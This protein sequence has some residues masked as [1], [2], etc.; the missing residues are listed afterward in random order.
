[1][2]KPKASLRLS[3]ETLDEIDKFGTKRGDR[4]R[5]IEGAIR[6]RLQRYKG[7]V[8]M[9]LPPMTEE[10]LKAFQEN[11]RKLVREAMEHDLQN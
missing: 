9:K 1:M 11:W 10:Q 3:R 7:L 2:Q 8:E 4:S 6:Q 5:F